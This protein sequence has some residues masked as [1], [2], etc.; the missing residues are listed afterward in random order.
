MTGYL[1][2]DDYAVTMDNGHLVSL[3]APVV[4]TQVI[5]Q[6]DFQG[7]AAVFGNGLSPTRDVSAYL[8]TCLQWR[9][10]VAGSDVRLPTLRGQSVD[11]LRVDS[12]PMTVATSNGQSLECG[13]LY[14]RLMTG[15]EGNNYQERLNEAINLAFG[16]YSGDTTTGARYYAA[17]EAVVD[18]PVEFYKTAAFSHALQMISGDITQAAGGGSAA[19][20]T[21]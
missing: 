16:K 8:E 12:A 6:E 1:G 18:D 2:L 5:T 4:Y 21:Q 17:L 19:S 15:F 20:C 3:R 14:D 9:A 10:K 13:T 7:P 11:E